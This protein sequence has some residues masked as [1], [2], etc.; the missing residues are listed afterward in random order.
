MKQ[1]PSVLVQKL[2]YVFMLAL[3]SL[4]VLAIFFRPTHDRYGI[5]QYKHSLFLPSING[6]A[7]R[8]F[9]YR[10]LLPVSVRTILSITPQNVQDSFPAFV[11]DHSY[12]IQIFQLYQWETGAAYSYFVATFLMWLCFIGFGHYAAKLTRL[13]LNLNETP[14]LRAL[15]A[16]SALLALPT[17]FCY[18]SYIYDPPQIFLFTLA[19][20]LLA[21]KKIWAFLIT[22]VFCVLNKE[23]AI[24]LIPLYVLLYYREHPRKKLFGTSAVLI[25]IYTVIKLYIDHVYRAN[26]GT[27]MEWHLFPD[28]FTLLTF[29]WTFTGFM[30]FLVYAFLLIYKWNEK[31]GFLKIA[32]LGTFPILFG[33]TLMFGLINEWR[34]YY[35]AYPVAFALVVDSLQRLGNMLSKLETP[36]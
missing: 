36:I 11:E 35:E 23:T 5:N 7:Y 2:G 17:L 12:T 8:P 29:G 32:F 21:S 10:V 26:L 33:M 20:Y 18:T 30:T 1:K 13:T 15:L 34:D 19:F 4:Y 22:F 25:V 14:F 31:P 9:V 28:N 24:L 6:T 27:G 16:G 3:V